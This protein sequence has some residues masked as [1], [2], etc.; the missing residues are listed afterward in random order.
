MSDVLEKDR[1]AD[2]GT[3]NRYGSAIACAAARL[4]RKTFNNWLSRKPAVILLSDEERREA[5]ERKRFS[6]DERRIVQ[7]A[8]TAELVALG[9][10][11]RRAAMC[12]VCFTD[13]AEGQEAHPAFPQRLPGE[14]FEG[15]YTFLVVPPG[16]AP[17]K[18]LPVTADTS[19]IELMHPEY[20]APFHTAIVIRI[21]DVVA[22]VKAAI[23]SGSSED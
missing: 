11:P 5:G 21:N 17:A 15:A 13:A 9:V 4:D 20:G 3:A 12:A 10:Q 23:A 1:V 14:L 7:I 22:R 16:D 18:V 8:L 2:A 6:F 19:V